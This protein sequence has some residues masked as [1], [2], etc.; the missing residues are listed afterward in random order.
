MPAVR[1]VP[2]GFI[3]QM[4]IKIG[5]IEIDINKDTPG[6]LISSVL[7]VIRHVEN[8]VKLRKE[9]DSPACESAQI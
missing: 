8:L 4:Q 2:S 3:P 9:S 1:S 6:E 7:G 5:D